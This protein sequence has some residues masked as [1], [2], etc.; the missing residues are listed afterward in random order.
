MNRTVTINDGHNVTFSDM[1]RGAVFIWD[2]EI[3]M[4]VDTFFDEVTNQYYNSVQLS[5]G[6]LCGFDDNDSL[7]DSFKYFPNITEISMR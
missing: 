7:T 1:P 5:N 4:K 6:E 2:D 3:Y